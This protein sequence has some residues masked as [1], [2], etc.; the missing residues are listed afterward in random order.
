MNK[1]FSGSIFIVFNKFVNF[2]YEKNSIFYASETKI[3]DD[4]INDGN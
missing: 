1:K 3:V 4:I 2:G